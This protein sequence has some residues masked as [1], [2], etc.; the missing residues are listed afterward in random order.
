[1]KRLIAFALLLCASVAA[2]AS[3]VTTL[4]IRRAD[5]TLVNYN[6]EKAVDNAARE[7]GL[8]DRRT[9]PQDHGM[10]F[11]YPKPAHIAFWMKDTYIPLDM[12]FFTADGTLAYIYANA[13]PESLATID[14]GRNDICAVLELNGGQAAKQNLQAGDKLVL[15]GPSACLP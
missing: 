3:D 15:S 5:G 9:M 13:K 1:M 4:S 2:C 14:P 6:V 7:H 11:L 8:M 10:I 12:L